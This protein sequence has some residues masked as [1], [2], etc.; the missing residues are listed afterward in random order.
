MHTENKPCLQAATPAERDAIT[1]IFV[2]PPLLVEEKVQLQN[3]TR[4]SEGYTSRVYM[5]CN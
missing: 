2:L 4:N 5:C 1:R 3:G